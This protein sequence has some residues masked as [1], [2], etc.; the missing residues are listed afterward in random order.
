MAK[1]KSQNTATQIVLDRNTST[2]GPSREESAQR[3]Y[4]LY[5]G[6]GGADGLEQED[7]LQAEREFREQNAS[8]MSTM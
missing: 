6:R 7:W 5:L 3:A 2:D 4:E 8:L 1:G